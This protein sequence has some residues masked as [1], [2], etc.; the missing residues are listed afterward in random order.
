MSLQIATKHHGLSGTNGVRLLLLLWSATIT[1]KTSTTEMVSDAWQT[2]ALLVGVSA[3]RKSRASTHG[4]KPG[5]AAAAETSFRLAAPIC[6][7]VSLDRLL[8]VARLGGH[9]FFLSLR[10]WST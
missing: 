4:E 2:D 1:K 10:E 7:E 5:V 9:A 6:P 3:A 8:V